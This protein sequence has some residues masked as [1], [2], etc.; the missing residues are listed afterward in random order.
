MNKQYVQLSQT[1]QEYLETII[2]K[3]KLEAKSSPRVL[4]LLE[5]DRG[6]TSAVVSKTLHVGIL[7]LTVWAMSSEG[8]YVF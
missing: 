3:G 8:V 6:Q 7:T 4:A 5:L 1:D 2:S